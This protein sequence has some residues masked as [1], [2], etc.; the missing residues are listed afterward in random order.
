MRLPIQYAFFYPDRLPLEIKPLDLFELGSLIF[1]K[2][3]METFRGLPLA[4]RA[5]HTG[6]SMPTIFNA[7]NEEAVSH[8]MKDEIEFLD[9]Y[10]LIEGAM[11]AHDVIVN[12]T[13]DQILET[14]QEAREFVRSRL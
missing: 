6:G 12:P 14:E 1:E 11:D 8:F 7:A 4:Y 5:A 2:P 9:I 10:D 3:D 13:L